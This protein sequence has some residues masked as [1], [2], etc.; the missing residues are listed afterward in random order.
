MPRGDSARKRLI[1]QLSS[2]GPDRATQYSRDASDRAERP[3][4]TGSPGQAGRRQ[5][6]V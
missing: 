3:R 5:R 6:S 4:R 2:P 1:P